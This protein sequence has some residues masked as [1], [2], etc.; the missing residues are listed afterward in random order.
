MAYTEIDPYKV[1]GQT[2]D[3]RYEVHDLIHRSSMSFVFRARDRKRQGAVA[4]KVLRSGDMLPRFRN[5]A[6]IGDIL[7]HPNIVKTLDHQLNGELVNEQT[8]HYIVTEWI[9]Q[10]SLDNLRGKVSPE[11]RLKRAVRY[12]NALGPTLDYMYNEHEIVHRDIKPS[13]ILLTPNDVPILID[14][15]I[16]KVYPRLT[17][18]VDNTDVGTAVGTPDFMSLEQFKGDILDGRSDQYSLAVTLYVFLTDGK[19]PYTKDR[20]A[21]QDEKPTKGSWQKAVER[22][23][24]EPI[25]EVESAFSYPVWNVLRKA[26]S[27]ELGDRYASSTEFAQ[28]FQAAAEGRPLP[29]AK[30]TSTNPRPI[31][32]QFQNARQTMTMTVVRRRGCWLPLMILLGIAIGIV[33]ALLAFAPSP[34]D[35]VVVWAQ[36][37]TAICCV[38]PNSTATPP[39]TATDTAS[40]TATSTATWTATSTHTATSTLTPTSSPTSTRTPTRTATPTPTRTATLT[41]SPTNTPTD[42]PVP[43]PTDMPTDTP[44]VTPLAPADLTATQQTHID[45]L[46]ATERFWAN[47]TAT[48]LARVALAA[49]SAN[50]TIAA[51]RTL[52]AA[53]ATDT[54][55]P[56]P[57]AT[58][59]GGGYGIILFSQTDDDGCSQLYLT[60]AEGT[61]VRSLARTGANSEQAEISADSARIVFLSD[62]GSDEPCSADNRIREIWMM[63]IDGNNRRQLTQ[64]NQILRRPSLSPDGTRIVFQVETVATETSPATSQ[65]YL[66]NTNGEGFQALTS[67]RD[68]SE[69]RRPQWSPDGRQIIFFSNRDGD[70]QIYRM[71]ADGQNQMRLL[72]SRSSDQ[73]PV[74]SPQGDRIA[75]FSLGSGNG[76]ILIVSLTG[77]EPPRLFGSADRREDTPIWS[78]D[79]AR[80]LVSVST[81]TTGGCR[82]TCTLA[83]YDY[84]AQT[85]SPLFDDPT[86]LVN[87]GTSWR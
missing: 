22:N 45:Q 25:Y 77:S 36:T 48:D 2:F 29:R 35:T 24:P 59:V 43:T 28:H 83:V 64:K 20:Q 8:V 61:F 76:D 47:S 56:E 27:S 42:T 55:T 80:I 63:D 6:A 9:G 3:N 44:T 75:Y 53:A 65:I 37:Q 46:V 85:L 13:N 7:K 86:L 41:A 21:H 34:A 81:S 52:I 50:E 62:R 23:K 78:P 31:T 68:G 49:I 17:T 66:M 74:L 14:L 18:Q 71:D 69:N 84:V 11:E 5:E 58:R 30:E 10:H 39:A 4:F 32:Q 79:G 57:T 87:E 19:N 26:L 40:P 73:R 15:G 82:N 51:E 70:Y 38:V 72:E 67:P 1:V 33:I 54:P 16:A 60:D 12:L